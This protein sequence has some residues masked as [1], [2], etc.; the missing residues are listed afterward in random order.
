[1]ASLYTYTDFENQMRLK[2]LNGQISEADL[3]LAKKN[4]DAGIKILDA[5]VKWNTAADDVE[6]TAAN[7]EA[8]KIRSTYGGYTGG[9]AGTEWNINAPKTPS[10]FSS[11]YDDLINTEINNFKKAEFKYD[12]YAEPLYSSYKKTYTR[13]GRRASEEAMAQAAAMT[14]GIPSSYAVMAGQ[15]AGNYYAGQMADKIPELEQMAY[16]RHLQDQNRRLELINLMKGERDTAY[17]RH[18][19]D[20]AYLQ[21]EEDRAFNR[22]SSVAGF[23]DFSQLENLGIVVPDYIK[24]AGTREL[25]WATEDRAITQAIQRAELGDYS[26]LENLGFVIPDYVKNAGPLSYQWSIEDRANETADRKLSNDLAI[27]EA[28][29]GVGDYSKY[30]G[31]GIN[32]DYEYIESVKKDKNKNTLD[33]GEISS[34]YGNTMIIPSSDV[35][36]YMQTDPEFQIWMQQNGFK[37]GLSEYEVSAIQSDYPDGIIP[38]DEWDTLVEAGY[39]DDDLADN[40]FRKANIPTAVYNELKDKYP[41]KVLTPTEMQPYIDAGYTTHDLLSAGFKLGT[42]KSIDTTDSQWNNQYGYNYGK[43][44]KNVGKFLK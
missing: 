41:G 19:D 8:E 4:P 7:K 26:A 40:G 20:I 1:M 35:M 24:N 30:E 18:L 23:G 15:Q 13:E 44:Y 31:M 6:K 11:E 42:K 17:D 5:K 37:I 32:P 12:P 25:D 36:G 38:S 21:G 16:N 9:E 22:A 14:G 2:G 27:A 43:D 28:A 33:Y 34:T 10:S 3:A 39:S 29:A